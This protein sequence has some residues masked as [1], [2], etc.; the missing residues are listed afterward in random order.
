MISAIIIIVLLIEFV[1]SLIFIV[2]WWGMTSDI[3]E[4]KR[5]L[6]PSEQHQL[7][8]LIVIGEKEA[9]QKAAMKMI[10]DILYPL[11][12]YPHDNIAENMNSQIASLLPKIKKLGIDLPQYLTSGEDFIQHMNSLTGNNVKY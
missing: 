2:R 8:Y 4:I 5:Y 1:I 12:F 3:K 9:A 10:A 6:T 11:Y 7:T